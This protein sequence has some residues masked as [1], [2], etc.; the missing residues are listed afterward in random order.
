MADYFEKL[1]DPRWQRK[2]L[3]IFSRDNWTCKDCGEKGKELQ[4]HHT[5]YISGKEPWEVDDCYLVTLCKSCHEKRTRE[6]IRYELSEE[7]MV[8][9]NNFRR[10]LELVRNEQLQINSK[11]I[12]GYEYDV[13]CSIYFDINNEENLKRLHRHFL[14]YIYESLVDVIIGGRK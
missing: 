12:K 1:K 9:I 14:S 10:A 3:R 5:A 11:V 7:E 4:V 13:D 6:N 8:L 2:R